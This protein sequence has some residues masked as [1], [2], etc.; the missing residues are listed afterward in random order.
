MTAK[1]LFQ[2]GKLDDAVQAQTAEVRNHPTDQQARTFLF[3]LLCFAGQ[4]DRAE[5]QL[6]AAVQGNAKG[7]LGA[8]L[9]R[10][11][12]NAEKTRQDAFEKKQYRKSGADF[13]PS[14]SGTINGRPFASIEDGDPRIGP[15]LELFAAGNFMW[16]PFEHLASVEMEPPKR[17]RDLLWAPATVRPGPSFKGAELGQVLLPAL[18]PFSWRSE[19]DAIRLG[20]ATAWVESEDSGALPVGQKILLI[21]GEEEF[22][23][24]ELRRLEFNPPSAGQPV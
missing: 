19:E 4:F 23:F 13:P 6:D 12:I 18:A 1:D 24:L 20:R 10:A 5:K 2:A 22:P 8:L 7:E 21:D 17:L 15:R 9:Y 11:A 16:L 3:E 14:P